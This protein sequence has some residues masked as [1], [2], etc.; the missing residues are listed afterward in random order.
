MFRFHVSPLYQFKLS[1]FLFLFA[2]SGSILLLGQDERRSATEAVG[3]LRI[4]PGLE[5][6]LFASEP[7]IASPTNIDIDDRGRVWV[8]E[9][10]N[11]RGHGARDQRPEGD[12]IL[13]MEDTNGDGVADLTKVFYQGRDV[14]AALG[15]CVFDGRV[16]VTCAPNV[17]QFMDEDGDDIPDSKSYLFTETGSPQNDHSTHSFVF[18]P[19]GHFYW[20][21]GNAGYSVHDRDGRQVYDQLGIPVFDQ[22]AS[23]RMDE[24]RNVK[25]QFWG[26]MV[27][28]C[29][30]SGGSF[31]VLGY[32]FR[33]N[34]EVTVDSYGNPWQSD[35]DDDGNYGVRLNYIM[36]HGNYGYLDELTGEGWRVPRVSAHA[37]VSSRHWHQNDPGVVPNFVQT[38]AGSPTGITVYEGDLLPERFRGKVLH[39]D[40]GPG[41]LWAA[42]GGVDGAG[43]S[44]EMVHL[45][46]S[47]T[48]K[49]FRPVDVSV[50]PDGS[51]FL[52]DWY[53]PVVG[54]NRQTDLG[55]GRIYRIAPKDHRY[56]VPVFDFKT[57]VGAKEALKSPTYSVRARAWRVLYGMETKAVTPLMRLMEDRDPRYRARAYWLLAALPED[58]PEYIQRAVQDSDPNIRLVGLRSAA[59]F[60]HPLIPVMEVLIDDPSPSV[61]RECAIIL[62]RLSNDLVP[63]LWARLA[64]RFDGED[65]WYLEALGI[66]AEGRWDECLNAFLKPG[67]VSSYS[68]LAVRRILWRSRSAATPRHLAGMLSAPNI[69]AEE[70]PGLLRAFDFQPE[71]SEK[72][73]QL[74]GLLESETLAGGPS[75][76]DIIRFQVLTRLA[77]T[78]FGNEP[79]F[80]DRVTEVGSSLSNP[81]MKVALIKRF[82][83]REM[84]D[85][86]MELAFSIGEEAVGQEAVRALFELGLADGIVEELEATETRAERLVYLVAR[87]GHRD[88]V[89]ALMSVLK[90][91]Q[92]SQAVRET[93]LRGLIEGGQGAEAVLDLARSGQFPSALT[94]VAGSSFSKSL[95]VIRR[96]AA[97]EFFPVPTLRGDEPL[98]GMT[99]MLVYIGDPERGRQVF[100]EATCIQCHQIDG[101]GT[102]FG[103][104]LSGIG[105]KLAKQG[106]YESILDPSAS[107]SPNYRGVELTMGS[108]EIFTGLI[109]SDS[110]DALVINQQGL[111][112]KSFSRSELSEIRYLDQ[113]VMPSGLQQLMSF[114]DLVDLVAFLATRRE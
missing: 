83:L 72:T 42:D 6:T 61:R 103:P 111:G 43:F 26:G 96:S 4:Y 30:L 8:C 50:A 82:E 98:P 76:R 64:A 95:H 10:Q 12:R 69:D 68:D 104:A 17:I 15:I 5:A 67:A 29:D 100:H 59:R 80:R 48:D 108:G 87:S 79:A 2:V 28:R 13:I 39:C 86:L 32:N 41:V 74:L 11:Y 45:V 7:L 60:G 52:S 9:V 40:A 56:R 19:D 20:N 53:D 47:P 112:L 70:V 46:E 35:N 54:W 90:N 16:I 58:G 85:D 3:N 105:A 25:G 88:A 97:A 33:N 49:W 73:R 109:V 84:R 1:G 24:Y 93:A 36:E 37:D 14:D 107:V 114:N 51:L 57:A 62:R 27:F 21:M 94:A 66:G 38:G 89:M 77:E 81:S 71:S 101:E 55:R 34:Y 78:S 91:E 44:A 102:A 22:R 63:A 18:G 92:H 113:S 31:E 75:S 23:Q 65:R 110:E 99:E 106:L